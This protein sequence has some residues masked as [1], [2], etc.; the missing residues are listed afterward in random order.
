MRTFVVTA[1][2]VGIVV[3][4]P[5]VRAQGTLNAPTSSSS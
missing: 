1:V 2:L 5:A 3:V 4:A